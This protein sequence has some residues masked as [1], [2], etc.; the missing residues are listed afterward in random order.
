[1]D[2]LKPQW[3][4]WYQISKMLGGLIDAYQIGNNQQALCVVTNLANWVKFRTDRLSDQNLQS[5]LDLQEFGGMNEALANLS[6]ITGNPDYLTVAQRFDHKAI[7][8]PLAAGLDHLGGLHAN[9]QIPKIIG[10]NREYQL[11]GVARY[12]TIATNFWN[13]VVHNHTYVIGGDSDYEYFQPPAASATHLSPETCETCN[14]YNML[15]LTRTLFGDEPKAEYMDYYE[16]TLYNHILASQDPVS[17]MM[18]YFVSLAPGRFKVYNQPEGSFW[19]CNSTGLEN[20]AKYGESIYYHTSDALFV[21][22]FIASELNWSAKGFIV[23]QET[24]FPDNNITTL[25]MNGDGPLKVHIRVPGWAQGMTVAINGTAQPVTATPD[26]YLTLDRTWKYGDRIDI[27][28][29][30]KLSIQRAPDDSACF[31]LMDGP[32][33]LAGQLGYSG[34]G[35]NDWFLVSDQA[36]NV[37]ISDAG[38]T[39]PRLNVGAG[40]LNN[41]IVPVAGQPLTFTTT[42][43]SDGSQ[44]TLNAFFRTHRQRYT[45]YWNGTPAIMDNGRA[46]TGYSEFTVA[47]DPNN[48]GVRLKR[49]FDYSDANQMATVSVNGT[50]VGTWFDSGNDAQRWRDSSFTIPASFTAGKSSITVHVAFVSSASDWNEFYYWV[51]SEGRTTESLTDSID[52]GTASSETAHNYIINAQTWTGRRNYRYSTITP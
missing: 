13:F 4:L 31:A 25:F 17:G 28:L 14:S 3:E 51:Y 7:Y 45:V 15:R 27:T 10:A 8:D 43:T 50:V 16:K 35:T 2:Q 46:F 40:T 26:T 30:M 49:R 22:L 21:N 19:C 47:I 34:L 20:H 33:V 41:L 23:R 24:S 5:Q 42:A 29:P 44:V 38:I 6:A 36:H 1:M 48:Q 12:H 37:N 9:T 52:V 18:C 32:I 11:T 39:V